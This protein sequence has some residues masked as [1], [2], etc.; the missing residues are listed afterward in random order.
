LFHV[1]SLRSTDDSE[2]CR[3]R[4]QKVKPSCGNC[5]AAISGQHPVQNARGRCSSAG[6]PP[7]PT[8]TGGGHGRCRAEPLPC[9][10]RYTLRSGCKQASTSAA[11]PPHS[12]RKLQA[13]FAAVTELHVKQHSSLLR[14]TTSTSFRHRSRP[15]RC[16]EGAARSRPFFGLKRI[17]LPKS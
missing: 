9:V 16:F 10:Q 6:T 4:F 3:I 14:R 12:Q 11:V 13:P 7:M 17:E 2:A 1:H 8:H 5:F 15:C